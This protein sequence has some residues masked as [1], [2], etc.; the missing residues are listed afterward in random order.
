MPFR[1]IPILLLS[2]NSIV[3]TQKFAKPQYIGDPLNIMKIF[4]EKGVDELIILD[5]NAS[6]NN[7]LNLSLIEEIASEAFIP[8]TYG[9]GINSLHDVEKLFK[10]GIEKVSFNNSIFT[11]INLVKDCVRNFGSQSVIATLDIKK[12]FFGQYKIY[13][14]L[15]ARLR[16][17]PI[18]EVL[19]KL[20]KIGVGEILINDV[21]RDGTLKGYNENL[22]QFIFPKTNT[23]ILHAGGLSGLSDLKYISELGYSAGCGGGYFIF[24]GRRNGILITYPSEESIE[25]YIGERFD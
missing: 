22:I 24:N 19:I 2:G 1:I 17:D 23:P 21:E 18:D 25:G 5:I 7:S 14:Y 4:N 20:E 12:S 3:K 6:R 10:L 15:K 13:S 8:L 11:N 16:V 9:G